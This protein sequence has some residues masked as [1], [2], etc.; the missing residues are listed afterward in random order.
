MSKAKKNVY[1]KK[2]E[3]MSLLGA[4]TT[5]L[6]TKGDMKNT[7]IETVKD[8]GVGV[9]G[10]GVV[11]AMIGKAS[12]A[13]GALI[14]GVGHYTKSR[15][16]SIFGIG[17]MASGGLPQSSATP[18]TPVSGTGNQDVIEGIKERVLNFKDTLQQKL[19]L[20]KILKK[21]TAPVVQ[22]TTNGVG[23]VQYFAAPQST[24]NLFGE[25][26]PSAELDILKQFQQQITKSGNAQ[27]NPGTQGVQGTE[28]S[29]Q[30]NMGDLDPTDK[31]Y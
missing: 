2:A 12:L 9:I 22:Q 18:A 23:E 20:D 19:F 26:L 28:D 21:K 30:W 6:E 7:A 17:M 29:A 4:I 24:E 14:A 15:L 25:G 3:E 16:T 11:G 5:D 27:L 13:V 10:G 1:E 8:I 31:N